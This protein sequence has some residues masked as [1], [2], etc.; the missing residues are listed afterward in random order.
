MSDAALQL[1]DGT[2]LRAVDLSLPDAPSFTGASVLDIAHS[3]VSSSLFA[4]SLPQSLKSSAL[5][6]LRTPDV[7]AFLS[8]EYA[9]DKAAVILR[10]YITAIADELKGLLLLLLLSSSADAL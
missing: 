6:R 8:A 7:D 5:T 4:L 2:H 1:L 9:A 3:R 10:D